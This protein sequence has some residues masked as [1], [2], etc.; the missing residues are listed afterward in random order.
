[1][2]VKK[3]EKLLKATGEL[4]QESAFT[5]QEYLVYVGNLLFTFGIAGLKANESFPNLKI[6]D[7]F[8]IELELTQ[9]PNNPY[10]ASIL[11]G[12]ALIKW[13]ESFRDE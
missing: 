7:A 8:S 5:D 4:M 2:N 10:L 13:S 9:N 1:M 3:I 11:Q 6:H 12:H